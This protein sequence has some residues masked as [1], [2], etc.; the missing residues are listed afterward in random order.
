M[1]ARYSDIHMADSAHSLLN[2]LDLNLL[3]TLQAL[4][5][6]KHVSRAAT[7]LGTTQPT[8]SRGLAQLRMAFGD[9][10]LLRTGRGMVLTPVGQS[11]IAPLDM[12]LAAL[13]RLPSIGSFDPRTARRHFRL[14]IPDVLGC[15]VIALL[16]QRLQPYPG[17]SFAVMGS[18]GDAVSSLLSGRTE[19]V[20]SAPTMEHSE[21]Y[22]KIL[23]FQVPWSALIGPQHPHWNGTLTHRAWLESEHVQLVP[24]GQPERSSELERLLSGRAEQRRIRVQVQYLSGVAECVGN[25]ALVATLPSPTAL[26]LAQQRNIR[27]VPHPFKKIADLKVRLTWHALHQQDDGHRWLRDLL[28]DCLTNFLAQPAPPQPK[29]R[30]VR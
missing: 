2:G 10:L 3:L 1:T 19:I 6:E 4:L 24:A 17:L 8:V 27:A 16:H 29:K 12:A 21:L 28:T 13:A 15:G 30:K 18:E 20:V 11:L 23:P 5:A 26:W 9:P 7:E 14:L 22:S 25:S